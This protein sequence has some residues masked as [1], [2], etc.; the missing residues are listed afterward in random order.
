MS[1]L[2]KNYR[3]VEVIYLLIRFNKAKF[4]LILPA[5]L[6]TWEKSEPSPLW[7]KKGSDYAE[8]SVEI[9][10]SDVNNNWAFRIMGHFQALARQI[11]IKIYT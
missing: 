5:L 1:L 3:L 8:N 6:F 10:Y 4:S 7:E 2:F 9:Q 11:E